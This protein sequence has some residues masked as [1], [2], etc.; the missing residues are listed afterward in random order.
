VPYVALRPPVSA[1]YPPRTG[2]HQQPGGAAWAARQPPPIRLH[3]GHAG[4]LVPRGEQ[5]REL[6]TERGLEAALNALAARSPVPACVDVRLEARLPAAHE[7]ALYF[8]AAEALTNAAKYARA[9]AVRLEVRESG[10]WAEITIV[11]DGVGG[12]ADA[13]GSGLRGLADRLESLGGKIAV[14]SPPGE[15]TTIQ[16]RVPTGTSRADVAPAW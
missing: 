12:A 15:G 3:G 4:E 13:T 9:T 8:V 2:R 1:T 16:A 14:D 7:A 5:L 11:D 6:L 10:E